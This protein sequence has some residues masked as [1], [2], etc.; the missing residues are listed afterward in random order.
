[1][2]VKNSL[3]QIEKRDV[4]N[5][6]SNLTYTQQAKDSLKRNASGENG[7]EG[8]KRKIVLIH[9]LGE[10]WVAGEKDV[11]RIANI[12]PPLGLCSLAAWVE[13]HGH[14]AFIHDCYA[15]PGDNEKIYDLVRTEQ[16]EFVGFTATTSAFLD[17]I[18]IAEK[19]KAIAPNTTIVCGGAHISALRESLMKDY[20]V[21]DYGVV[22]EGG[23]YAALFVAARSAGVGGARVF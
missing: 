10:C 17:G 11:A 1:M 5:C 23:E 6:S 7:S 20:P 14:Q 4:G 13:Q 19:I 12:M 9:P 22:G 15:H 3:L 18:R 21:I 2:W 8:V 16:P